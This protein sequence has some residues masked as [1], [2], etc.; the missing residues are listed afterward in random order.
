MSYDDYQQLCEQD[1]KAGRAGVVQMRD[2]SG[3]QVDRS[4]STLAE[5]EPHWQPGKVVWVRHEDA[6]GPYWRSMG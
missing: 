1:F 6:R 3:H 5:I 4:G 2:Q